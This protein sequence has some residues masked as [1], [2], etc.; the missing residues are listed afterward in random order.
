MMLTKPA[1]ELLDV[2]LGLELY[3]EFPAL[4]GSDKSTE[5][6]MIYAEGIFGSPYKTTFVADA[7]NTTCPKGTIQTDSP[8]TLREVQNHGNVL[9]FALDGRVTDSV[10]DY[11]GDY[12]DNQYVNRTVKKFL[13]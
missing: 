1:E 10:S 2:P 11:E 13:Y 3:L 5:E 8:L 6:M 4:E 7:E 12:S 9:N